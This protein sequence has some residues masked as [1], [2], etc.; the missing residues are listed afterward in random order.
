MAWLATRSRLKTPHP[1][2]A[3]LKALVLSRWR[4]IVQN[5]R[6]Q[7]KQPEHGPYLRA[8]LQTP[9]SAS[10]ESICSQ[11]MYGHS[12]SHELCQR[13]YFLAPPLQ[14]GSSST[15]VFTGAGRGGRL[16]GGEITRGRL[17]NAAGGSL[18]AEQLLHKLLVVPWPFD[19]RVA[20]HG[21]RRLC[22]GR[23]GQSPWSSFRRMR[24]ALSGMTRV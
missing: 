24:H 10:I 7:W 2:W 19:T 3:K 17:G 11:P 12:D 22:W 13:E 1:P 23:P 21:H 16:T 18:P 4:H 20:P 9:P 5:I 6:L 14:R 15:V 8:V